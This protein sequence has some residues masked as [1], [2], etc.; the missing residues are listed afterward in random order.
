MRNF[1]LANAYVTLRSALLRLVNGLDLV[2]KF[3]GLK[4]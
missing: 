2:C 3:P 4:A 1:N